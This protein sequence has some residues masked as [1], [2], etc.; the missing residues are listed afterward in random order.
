MSI[1]STHSTIHRRFKKFVKWVA[2][3][4]DTRD[5]IRNQA[6]EI[7]SKISPKAEADNLIITSTPIT[8]SFA[9]E[10]GLRR[11]MLGNSVEEGQDVDIAFIMLPKDKLSRELG[12]LV[13]QF[14]RYAKEAY[15]DSEVDNTKS[16]AT[17]V[18]KSTKLKYDLVPL[19]ETRRK[20][21]QNL[22]RYGWK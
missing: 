18:F 16:S 14:K 10:S 13:Y 5:K 21:I 1:S 11:Y 19:F 15:P 17:I 8:G 2:P 20:N 22:K 6:D 12:C 4:S 3:E 7:I 9:K